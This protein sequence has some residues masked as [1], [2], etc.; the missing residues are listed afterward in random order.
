VAA[1]ASS[2]RRLPPRPA[3]ARHDGCAGRVLEREQARVQQPQSGECVST[4]RALVGYRVRAGCSSERLLESAEREAA[5]GLGARLYSR[6]LYSL[7]AGGLGARLYSRGLYSL[8][9]G[10]LGARLYSRGLYSLAPG[11]LGARAASRRRTWGQACVPLEDPDAPQLPKSRGAKEP[12][13][14]LQQEA[15]SGA[16]RRTTA[17]R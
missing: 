15:A 8:A 11:G 14:V 2:S 1:H 17:R 13:S 3:C 5:G 4:A 10:G 9:A 12:M 6:G 7:A 16:P